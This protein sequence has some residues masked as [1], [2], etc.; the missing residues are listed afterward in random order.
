[1]AAQE[2]VDQFF[3]DLPH[4]LGIPRTESTAEEPA[5]MRRQ[6]D[7]C[8]SGLAAESWRGRRV[9]RPEGRVRGASRLSVT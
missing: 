8:G 3:M 7:V 4:S 2:P 9:R 1:M 5:G 6:P